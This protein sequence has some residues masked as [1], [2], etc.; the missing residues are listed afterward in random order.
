[1]DRGSQC[2]NPAGLRRQQDRPMFR[3]TQI[4]ASAGI[5]GG[6]RHLLLLARY[7]HGAEFRF[8]FILPEEGAL[9]DHLRRLDISYAIVPMK[10]KLQVDAWRQMRRLL[11]ANRTDLAH[12]HG[13][14]GNW[15]GRT[16]ARLA[17]AGVIFSTVHNSLKDYP[18]P[19]W[20]RRLYVELEKCTAGFVRQWIA[21][22]EAVR[23]D[24]VEYYRRP[25]AKIAVVPNGID[26]D[27]LTVGRSREAV[28]RDLGLEPGSCV[29][30]EAARMTEQK[31]H[32]FLLEA[33]ALLR[34]RVPGLH[35][36]LAGDG[37]TRLG[38]ERQAQRLKVAERVHF[39]GFR[40][41]IADLIDA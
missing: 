8:D 34:D 20:R 35:C 16:A 40:S 7:L 41:D 32:R 2:G 6:E 10:T 9:C 17:G 5:G 36:L 13:A 37:P 1:M 31:G 29:L 18:Y 25:A 38:L 26:V 19:A 4:N 33:V 15:Y 22:S 30:L 11:Q 28:R 21:V 3:V 12:C 39:L 27:D 24:L 14:R 23:R